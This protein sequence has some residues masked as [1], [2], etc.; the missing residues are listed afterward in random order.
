MARMNYKKNA[1]WL[2]L[3][4]IFGLAS[5][6]TAVAA[7]T[8]EADPVKQALALADA[9]Q[10]KEALD[11]LADAIKAEPARPELYFHRGMILVRTNELDRALSNFN[12]ASELSPKFAQA[13][14]GRAM[15]QFLKHDLDQ[16]IVELDRAVDLDPAL[17]VAYYNRGVAKSYKEQ[18]ESAYNDL[19]K[20]KALGHTV[21]DELLKQVWGLAHPEEVIKVAEEEIQKDPKKG[22][23]YYNRAVARYYKKDF[24]GTLQDLNKA[25][26]LGID[27]VDDFIKAV[28]HQIDHPAE[29]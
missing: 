28:Q 3:S 29:K 6:G 19:A 25:K 26:S 22:E 12:K 24:T 8:P 1:A 11:Q 9:G 21:E 2:V 18:F 16:T 15:V 10:N 27:S 23:A 7:D 17:A 14:V 20:A 4:L 13:Y 5:A